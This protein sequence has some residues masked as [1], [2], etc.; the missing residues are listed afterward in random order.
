[1]ERPSFFQ[2][3]EEHVA[4]LKLQREALQAKAR[5]EPTVLAAYLDKVCQQRLHIFF[6]VAV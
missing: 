4:Q 5:E 2:Q 3:E 1:M 6:H